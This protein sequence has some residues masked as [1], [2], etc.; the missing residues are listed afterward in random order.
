MKLT[1]TPNSHFSRKVR[2]LMD[3]LGIEYDLED[4]GNV[5][6][7]DAAGFA[8]NP[9]MSV[10]VLND[11][12]RSIIDSD[13]IA[14][15][16]V[17]TYDP[18]DQYHV[19]TQETVYLNARAV[20]NG[21]MANDVKLLLSARTG[22]HPADYDYFKKAKSSIVLSLAWLESHSGL[23]GLENNTYADFHLVSMWDHLDFYNV[24][25]MEY[26][27]LAGV[28]SRVSIQK[29]VSHSAPAK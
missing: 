12:G 11:Q 26:P 3:H 9:L 10:P 6:E 28:V 4:V 19:L 21:I 17:R 1:A 23:F 27:S 14:Q 2:L 16:I 7:E 29:L 13:H 5:A 18:S 25:A 15:Y 20:M 24:V 22:L 8:G